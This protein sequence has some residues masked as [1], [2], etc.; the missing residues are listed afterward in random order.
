MDLTNAKVRFSYSAAD[1]ANVTRSGSGSADD[2]YG[3]NKGGGALRLWMKDGVVA[4]K[5]AS[6][7][8]VNAANRGDF[9]PS[10]VEIPA[11]AITKLKDYCTFSVGEVGSSIKEWNSE[12]EAG[13]PTVAGDKL[14]A[15]VTFSELPADNSAFGLKEAKLTCTVNGK[16]EI[17]NNYEVFF[18]A[19]KTNHPACSV[20][21]DCPNWFYYYKQASGGGLYKYDAGGGR[22]QSISA[23]GDI[24]VKISDEAYNGDNYITTTIQDGFLKVTG[25]SAEV[26]YYPNFCGV[27]A[28]ERQH[29]NN[30]TNAGSPADL[31][32]DRLSNDFET[33]TSKTDPEDDDSAN[34]IGTL[35]GIWYDREVY[36]G[37]PVEQA[38][39]ENADTSKDWAFPGIN[40]R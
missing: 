24:S 8:E 4:R 12:N 3:Y 7:A 39:I 33:N 38:G 23:G 25:V 29:A 37:G 2:P 27:L 15:T 18:P 17:K 5:K 16:Y 22:S 19:T 13:V 20:C 10:G 32:E 14:K 6:V 21:A 9:V 1:P 35:P 34:S 28:H 31:D 11:A 40:S 26:K 36:A 30:Q